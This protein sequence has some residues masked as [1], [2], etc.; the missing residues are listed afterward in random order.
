MPE[1]FL[2][3]LQYAALRGHTTVVALLIA[4]GAI[5]NAQTLTGKT[6]LHLAA[7]AGHQEVVAFLLT[8]GADVRVRNSDGQTPL[9][10]MRASSL[11]PAT[12]AKLAPMLGA[13]RAPARVPN[14]VA[15][16]MPSPPV[17]PQAATPNGLTQANPDAPPGALAAAVDRFQISNDV[18]LA[19]D[20]APRTRSLL[21]QPQS[22]A[23]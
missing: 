3:P 19:L 16:T 6:A 12:K 14:P 7:T 11:D 1:I 22:Y 10:E 15:A 17:N 18:T 4:R 20:C 8:R 9:Q 21:K 2:A 5:V 23:P 13:K